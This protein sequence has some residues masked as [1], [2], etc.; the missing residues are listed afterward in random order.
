MSKVSEV[1]KNSSSVVLNGRSED[2][3]ADM[4]QLLEKN[5][6]KVAE[7][8]IVRTTVDVFKGS[9][10]KKYLSKVCVKYS[11]KLNFIEASDSNFFV[12]N[13]SS[14]EC[15]SLK[16]L[17]RSFEVPRPKYKNDNK[18]GVNK[19]HDYNVEVNLPPSLIELK[20]IVDQPIA[21]KGFRV[22][23]LVWNKFQIAHFAEI[24][25]KFDEP[26]FIFTDRDV[27]AINDFRVDFLTQIGA[28]T[29]FCREL[30]LDSLD[31]QYDAILT[32]FTPPLKK[33]WKKTKLVMCQ[34]SLA[35]AK[36]VYNGRWL[37]S[38]F[39]LVYGNYSSDIISRLCP[40][41][42]VGNPRFDPYF[43]GRLDSNVIKEINKKLDK[44]KK[45]VLFLPTW[46]DLSSSTKYMTALVN[47][48]KKYNVIYKPHHM[49][50]IRDADSL[51]NI[52]ESIIYYGSL[53]DVLDLGPYLYKVADVVVSDMSG[54][55]FDAL[56]CDKPVVLLFDSNFDYINHKKADEFSLEI[57]RTDC[58]GPVVKNINLLSDAVS[59]VLSN[60]NFYV[61]KNKKLVKEVFYK[62]GGCSEL[63]HK[64]ITSYLSNPKN[65]K[66]PILKKSV[67]NGFSKYL[68]EKAYSTATRRYSESLPRTDDT[69]S[70]LLAE[71]EKPDSKLDLALITNLLKE[72][73][74]VHRF[75]PN[76]FGLGLALEK[77]FGRKEV[78]IDPNCIYKI[79]DLT[80]LVR[81]SRAS[82]YKN[83]NYCSQVFINNPL[84]NLGAFRNLGFIKI[85]IELANIDGRRL[86][87]SVTRLLTISK[88]FV[89]VSHIAAINQV[90]PVSDHFV[91]SSNWQLLKLK[92][93]SSLNIFEL[94]YFLPKVR[95]ESRDLE[96]RSVM[97]DFTD[98]IFSFLIS[99][100]KAV[101]PIIQSNVTGSPVSGKYTAFSWH[102]LH[103]GF[104]KQIHLKVGTFHKSVIIDS[105]GYSGWSSI[106]DASLP[107]LISDV[108]SVQANKHYDYLYDFLVVNKKSKFAQPDD[109]LKI[110]SKYI[111]LPMQVLDDTVAKLAYINS[112]DLLHALARWGGDNN[113]LIVV[114]RHPLCKFDEVEQALKEY[115]ASG[116]IFV[117]DANIHDLIEGSDYV[118]TVNSGVGAEALLHLKPVI[119][120][121]KSDYQSVC[122]LV[123]TKSELYETL[124]KA[125]WNF[126]SDD[127]IKKFL[128]FYTKRYMP[129]Y[130]DYEAIEKTLERVLSELKD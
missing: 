70:L 101:Y 90:L 129:F 22:G 103:N 66:Q 77:L 63:A 75:Q 97:I 102:T 21:K 117:S 115:E 31:G 95:G 29:R 25:K 19:K 92:E 88:D 5:N 57:N 69:L 61:E 55:I 78:I 119:C 10:I 83:L 99:R 104:S 120:T 113:F 26:D 123:K 59:S 110:N 128:W 107:S 118:V 9:R 27:S 52:D 91:I 35:K 20:K 42:E 84:K 82:L 58:I 50:T 1:M 122:K 112:L 51:N 68:L 12:E 94:S 71:V 17:V 114:K 11:V 73:I 54:A 79:L 48:T 124:D 76:L 8:I 45:T 41:A 65:H 3:L 81:Y 62:K 111:F 33:K 67:G 34:Y 6:R 30:D 80:S 37:A 74:R 108:S 106:S 56:Y 15:N 85:Y 53:P 109:L 60:N 98:S 93:V 96:N 125:S 4:L 46:G 36:T 44:T 28:Y 39:A 116:K 47:L 49:T 14:S 18:V 7:R 87:A 32:Q 23:F 72:Q 64:A 89:D 40:V 100:G 38:D 86:P 13:N 130:D 2:E 43:E 126:S 24:A 16:D 105:K 121:G 127:E